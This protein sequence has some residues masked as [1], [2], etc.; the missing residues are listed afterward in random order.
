MF[1]VDPVIEVKMSYVA[2]DKINIT[3]PVGL[4]TYPDRMESSFPD[5]FWDV[6]AKA[7]GAKY[8]DER[9]TVYFK[10]GRKWR[11][12]GDKSHGFLCSMGDYTSP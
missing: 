3:M 12:I 10:D 4:G 1:D 6:I 8:S 7:Y 5:G 9:S 2:S 11:N